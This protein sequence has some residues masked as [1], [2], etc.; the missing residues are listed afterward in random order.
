MPITLGLVAN[1]YNE[2]NALPGWLDLHIDLFDEIRILHTGPRGEE[3]NDGTMELLNNRKINYIMDTIDDGFGAA[4]T[5][6]LRLSSCD[7][8]LLLD[9]DERFYRLQKHLFCEGE[10]TPH[11]EVDEILRGY[12]F[13]K[14]KVPDW[15]NLF[16]LGSK[17]EVTKGEEYNQLEQLRKILEKHRPDVVCMPRRHWHDFS[18]KKPTQNWNTDPDWQMRLVRNDPS[19]FFDPNIRMHERLVGANK[20]YQCDTVTGPFIDHFHFVFKKMECNQRAHDVDT[21]NKIHAGE[22]PLTY[23]EFNG[24]N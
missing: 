23:K 1:I 9:A 10:G 13:S 5:R 2:V 22:L 14:G 12:N 4:R 3:S 19:I 8:V 11:N 24:I 15:D 7:Y 21:Y 18:F 17:L 16:K 20:P 6:A